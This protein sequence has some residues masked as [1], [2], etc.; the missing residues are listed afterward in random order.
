MEDTPVDDDD[1][2]VPVDVDALAM[3]TVVQLYH[4]VDDLNCNYIPA[5]AIMRQQRWRM[6]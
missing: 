3:F 5:Y 2:D 1:A 4:A 6:I